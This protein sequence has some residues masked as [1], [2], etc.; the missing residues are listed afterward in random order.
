VYNLMTAGL[1]ITG[2]VAFMTYWLTVTGDA[3][4]A[5]MWEDGLPMQITDTEYLNDLGALLWTTP[6]QYVLM[7]GPLV[8]ILF[9]SSLWRSLSA[10]AALAGFVAISA[11]I[12]VSFSGLA[13]TYTNGSIAQ[14]FFVA[15]RL[16]DRQGPLGLGIVPVDGPVR[17]HRGDDLQLL[18]ALRR[19]VLCDQCDRRHR[20]CG[21]HR[22]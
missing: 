12:G 22:L 4:K 11:L 14:M 19:A 13:L 10:G 21:V 8:I 5:A 18:L 3:A 7:F 15:V 2:C 16:F 6:L 17:H 9:T 1:A 20:V